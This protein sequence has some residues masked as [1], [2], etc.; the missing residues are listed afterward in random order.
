MRQIQHA[1]DVF[2]VHE[3][4]VLVVSY[5]DALRNTVATVRRL[6]S[7]LQTEL[8]EAVMLKVVDP[9]LYRERASKRLS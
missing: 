1:K 7:F 4:P 9:D 6:G 2:E 5:R 3:V 8:D